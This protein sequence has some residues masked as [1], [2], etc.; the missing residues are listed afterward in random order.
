[1]PLAKKAEV[2]VG[3]W[4]QAPDPGQRWRI[5]VAYLLVCVVWGST[6]IAMRLTL[7]GFPPFL[8]A[9]SRFTIAGTLLFTV[10]RLRGTPVPTRAEWRGS[11]LIGLLL[12]GANVGVVIAQQWVATGL[13]AIAG[14]AVPLWV[15]VINI[16]WRQYPTRRETLGLAIGFVGVIFLNLQR[17]FSGNPLGA[18]LLLFAMIVWSL[19]SALR[20]RIALPDG[21][22]AAAAQ[23]LLG[24]SVLLLCSLALGERF[25]R[26][27]APSALGAFVYLI[28]FGSLIGFS[29][30][31]Y[32]LQHARPALA[33]SYAYVNP[34]VAVALGVLIAGETVTPLAL[35]AMA[36]TLSGV[37]WI[38][39]AKRT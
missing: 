39:Q 21:L 8:M 3:E 20:P 23:M 29:A 15:A 38:T 2:P 22:M 31:S 36:I 4:P 14:A 6:Y 32:L 28:L 1:M 18:A 19:G 12:M 34:L 9:G 33:T 26:V 27:P 16:F 5:L 10:L 11:L 13:A 37:A 17:E 35:V 7:D 30:Y 25:T 24:G